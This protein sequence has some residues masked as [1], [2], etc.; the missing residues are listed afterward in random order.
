MKKS[1]NKY[2][3]S[4]ANWELIIDD[5]NSHSAA[6]SAMIMAFSKFGKKL[7]MSTTIMVRSEEDSLS[8]RVMDADFFATHSIMQ[9]LG[10][11]SLSES[12][13][14]FERASR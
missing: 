11:D 8:D 10:L 9:Q 6:V 5:M 14:E 7:L 12:F 2:V 13:K 1:I 4:S 3:V